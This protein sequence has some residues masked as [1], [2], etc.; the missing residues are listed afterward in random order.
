MISQKC[1]MAAFYLEINKIISSPCSG[2]ILPIRWA[3]VCEGFVTQSLE[4]TVP[5]SFLDALSVT[6]M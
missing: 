4:F 6:W 1:A 3:V 5:E 2:G